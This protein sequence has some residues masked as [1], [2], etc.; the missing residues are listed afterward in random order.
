MRR[1][2]DKAASALI[3]AAESS[4][5]YFVRT[6]ISNTEVGDSELELLGVFGEFELLGAVH[7]RGSCTRYFANEV[8]RT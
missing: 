4:C 3:S 1:A 8:T 6:L 5:R 7:V 2:S